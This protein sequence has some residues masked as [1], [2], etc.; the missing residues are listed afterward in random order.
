MEETEEIEYAASADK[1]VQFDPD[2]FN[3]VCRNRTGRDLSYVEFSHP[4]SGKGTLYYLTS[5]RPIR[6]AR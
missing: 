6:A 4:D 2:D 3:R 1:A 5:P